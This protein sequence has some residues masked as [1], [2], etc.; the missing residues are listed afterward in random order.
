MEE[1]FFAYGKAPVVLGVA[2]IILIG[3][4]WWMT[5]VD[6]KLSKLEDQINEVK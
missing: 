2:V 5:K 4:G 6:K 3:L 1:V